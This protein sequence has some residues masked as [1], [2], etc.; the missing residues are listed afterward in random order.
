MEYDLGFG[1]EILI[2]LIFFVFHNDEK[3][4]KIKMSFLEPKLYSILLNS[5]SREKM[6]IISTRGF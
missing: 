4:Q 5:M 1:N 6:I 2:F 3:L